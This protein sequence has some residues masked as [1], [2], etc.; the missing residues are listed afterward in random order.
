MS[1]KRFFNHKLDD[2]HRQEFKLGRINS[3]KYK[4]GVGFEREWQ[5][6][7]LALP[8][9]TQ[10]FE[11]QMFH[12]FPRVGEADLSFLL[13]D[14]PIFKGLDKVLSRTLW[15]CRLPV[16]ADFENYLLGLQLV[17]RQ[18]GLVAA[19]GAMDVMVDDPFAADAGLKG[20]GKIK[21]VAF[22][23]S[24]N[25]NVRYIAEGGSGKPEVFREPPEARMTRLANTLLFRSFEGE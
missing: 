22:G 10:C 9:T 23:V 24:T 2:F 4:T 16:Y 6:F 14:K 12:R 13:F 11:D 3:S 5:L 15:A 7:S 19:F 8:C 18:I 20:Q 17:N 21:V 1:I 25:K